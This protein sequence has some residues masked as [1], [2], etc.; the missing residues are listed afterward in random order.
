MLT[1]IKRVTGCLLYYNKVGLAASFVFI[2][3][4]LVRLEFTDF[5]Y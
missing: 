3:V 1:I 2:D 5:F 4:L